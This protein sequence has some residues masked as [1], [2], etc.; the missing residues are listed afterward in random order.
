[1]S[2]PRLWALI[3]MFML[4][5]TSCGP[6]VAESK[7]TGHLPNGKEIGVSA[8]GPRGT[9][10]WWVVGTWADVPVG[11]RGELDVNGPVSYH[12]HGTFQTTFP[13]SPPTIEASPSEVPSLF[14][15]GDNHSW[16]ALDF[17]IPPGTYTFTLRVFSP[18]GSVSTTLT[19][20]WGMRVGS[21]PPGCVQTGGPTP[22]PPP[23]TASPNHP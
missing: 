12:C 20:E 3:L 19:S 6:L 10:S 7:A 5:L 1:M 23:T 2:V 8:Q 15:S 21:P 16:P 18:P 17:H 14:T 11:T 9:L 4:L 22:R 13:V